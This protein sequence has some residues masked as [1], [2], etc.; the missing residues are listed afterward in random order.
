MLLTILTLNLHSQNHRIPQRMFNH[1]LS[2][3]PRGNSLWHSYGYEFNKDKTNATIGLGFKK[4]MVGLNMFSPDKWTTNARPN[5]VYVS[6]NYVYRNKDYKWFMLL[7]GFGK[8]VDGN[9]QMMFRV[10]ADLQVAYPFFITTNFYQTN[11]SQLMIGG[12]IIIF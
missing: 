9:N 2:Y 4:I 7:A 6:L 10:G 12:K 5:E 3:G 11:Q 8:S 1:T